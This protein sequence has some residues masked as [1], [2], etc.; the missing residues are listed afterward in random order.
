MKFPLHPACAAWPEIPPEAL[1]EL[2]DDIRANGLREP[3]TLTPD[4]LLLDGRNRMLAC[5][6]ADVEP[7]TIVYAGDPVAFSL[8]KNKHRRHMSRD[9]IALAMGALVTTTQGR[10]SK[11]KVANATFSVAD[12]A[13]VSGLR[14][15]EI[16][17][18]TTVVRDGTEDEIAAVKSGKAKLRKTADAVRARKAPSSDVRATIPSASPVTPA[19]VE[20][21]T[22]A[23][24][25]IVNFVLGYEARRPGFPGAAGIAEALQIDIDAATAGLS[26]AIEARFAGTMPPVQFTE[27]QKKHVD[28]FEE[29]L[30]RRYYKLTGAKERELQQAQQ[31]VFSEINE[32]VERQVGWMRQ[33][34]TDKLHGW[35]EAHGMFEVAEWRLLNMAIQV[36]ASDETRHKAAQLLNERAY[37]A[38]GGKMGTIDAISRAKLTY[39]EAM[40][41]KAAKA[42]ATREANKAKGSTP[43]ARP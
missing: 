19:P 38:T 11:E 24:S 13:T 1:H 5:E 20:P 9:Q 29:A 21:R 35:A 22:T 6:L 4:G 15:D 37:L 14:E 28:A 3:I 30:K 42:K 10:P 12:A 43:E 33:F 8:S 39:A 26:L 25:E 40:A 41:E 17:S 2:A 16:K 31:Q 7:D 34:A 36:N 32:K 27:A 18:A 23:P